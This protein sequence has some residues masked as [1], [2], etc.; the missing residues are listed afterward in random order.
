MNTECMSGLLSA[1]FQFPYWT[2]LIM[3]IFA[4]HIMIVMKSEVWIISPCFCLGHEIWYA[5]QVLLC[6]ETLVDILTTMSMLPTKGRGNNFAIIFF[7]PISELISKT[8]PVKL[9]LSLRYEFHWWYNNIHLVIDSMSSW[10]SV[11][12]ADIF[13]HIDLLR[14][15]KEWNRHMRYR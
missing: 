10:S 15:V 6:F 1:R 13:R 4:L 3:R 2:F 7:K 11:D 12:D 9:V 8:I 14:Y 5:L